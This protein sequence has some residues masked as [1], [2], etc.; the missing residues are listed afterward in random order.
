MRQQVQRAGCRA[1][2]VGSDAQVLG[3]GREAAMTEEELNG[4]QISAGFEEMNSECVPKRML[5]D[6]FGVT[7]QTM[8][9]L[10]VCFFGDL[11]DR[12]IYV[13][14]WEPPLLRA[15]GSPLAAQDLQQRC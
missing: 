6:R 8:C 15:N 3:C 4:P 10:A 14:A 2:L 11:R 5:R 13:N 12:P 7:S 1:D 9:L